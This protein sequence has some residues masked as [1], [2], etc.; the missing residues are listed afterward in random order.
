MT[1]YKYIEKPLTNTEK[2]KKIGWKIV[3][4]MVDDLIFEGM[5][6]I[7]KMLLRAWMQ[8]KP[9]LSFLSGSPGF[10]SFSCFRA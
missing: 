9:G 3:S 10:E 8:K 1:V 6:L 4:F 7:Y 2:V 5:L